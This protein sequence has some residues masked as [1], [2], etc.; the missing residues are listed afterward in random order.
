MKRYFL[1]LFFS[2]IALAQ[3]SNVTFSSIDSLSESSSLSS[4][5]HQIGIGLSKFVNSAFPSDSNAFLLEYRYLKTPAVAYRAGGD[6]HIES[7]KDS[8]YEVALKIGIDK[9]FRNYKKWKFYYGI[10]LGSRYLYYK[11]R[12]QYFIST[13]LN[14]FIGIQYQLSQNFSISTEPGFFLKY[15]FRK[16]LKSFDS[17]NQTNWW[18]S[19][20]AKIGFLQLNFHF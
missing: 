10:D 13:T 1:I 12:E 6:Y 11:N 18:E 17:Q 9:L 14:P 7:T 4:C 8:R 16:D 20:L 15:N 3:E 5:K 2:N 19:R